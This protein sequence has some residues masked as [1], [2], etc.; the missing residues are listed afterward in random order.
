MG[1]VISFLRVTRCS[2]G[3][4][5]ELTRRS[6]ALS[7]TVGPGMQRVI[8]P[9][10][11]SAPR[12]L[13]FCD[14]TGTSRYDNNNLTEERSHEIDPGGGRRGKDAVSLVDRAIGNNTRQ[15]PN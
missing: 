4:P 6:R 7:T 11:D 14:K 13:Y 12:A 2:S 1:S 3:L 8:R 15:R 10:W 9:A 5:A